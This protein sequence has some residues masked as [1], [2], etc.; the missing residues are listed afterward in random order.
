MAFTLTLLLTVITIR[1][2]LW[3]RWGSR[4]DQYLDSLTSPGDWHHGFT[5]LLISAL[6]LTFPAGAI[7]SGGLGLG[8]GL[9]ADEVMLPLYA[10]GFRQLTYW[11]PGGLALVAVTLALITAIAL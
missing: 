11:S 6:C 5:G 10:L 8:L 1:L 2:S 7:R 3:S 4:V 9:M